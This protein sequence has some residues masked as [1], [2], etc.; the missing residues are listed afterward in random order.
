MPKI[1]ILPSHQHNHRITW[2]FNDFGFV[3]RELSWI[4]V[5]KLSVCSQF[6][7]FFCATFIWTIK[8]LLRENV[9]KYNWNVLPF[10]TVEHI[11]WSVAEWSNVPNRETKSCQEQQKKKIYRINCWQFIEDKKQK[12]KNTKTFFFWFLLIFF[13]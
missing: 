11:N 12:E 4:F 1:E 7:C 8:K 6:Y 5:R 10:S 3:L 2:I 9:Y 13:N